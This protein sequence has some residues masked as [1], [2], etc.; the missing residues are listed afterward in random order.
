MISL[1]KMPKLSPTMEVG[2]IVKWH[3]NNGDKI[4]FG[5]VLLEVSTDKAVLE[6]TANEEGWFRDCL[7]KEGTKVHIGTPIAVISSEKDEDFNLDTILPKTPE[8]EL[9]V[10]NVQ[11]VEEE[12][13]K[14]Q[15]SVASMQLAFQF[16]PE[17]PLSKPLSLK[18]DSSKSPISP[19]AKRVAKE[20]TWIFLES[21]VA[22]LADVLLKKTWIKLLPKVLQVLVTLKLLKCIL[23]PI[24]RKL[25]LLFEISLHR[26][27]KLRKPLFHIFM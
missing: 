11:L 17:P 15:P 18:V 3:K 13:T 25:F 16:K 20:K 19:L 9:P 14:V 10:E 5:D 21:K 7:V 27:Y 26:G 4:E 8:P 12:V 1:L 23:D 24:T 6:H 22:V 2:T